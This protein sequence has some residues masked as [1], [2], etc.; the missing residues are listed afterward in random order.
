[1]DLHHNQG[2]SLRNAWK[3][4]KAEARSNPWYFGRGKGGGPKGSNLYLPDTTNVRPAFVPAERP[5]DDATEIYSAL[6][7]GPYY[8]T[9]KAKANRRRGGG[10]GGARGNPIGLTRNGQPYEVLPNGQHRFITKA[11]ARKNGCPMPPAQGGT[12]QP[13]YSQVSGQFGISDERHDGIQPYARRNRRK[14]K[15]NTRHRGA[16]SNPEASEAMRLHHST[17]MSLKNAWKQVRGNRSRG[18]R[19]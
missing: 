6:V 19:R 12:Y 5:W 18:R 10:R 15:R 13:N 17:G 8:Q 2:M 7:P 1:M 3:K 11:K 9:K 14:T 16:R 4:V